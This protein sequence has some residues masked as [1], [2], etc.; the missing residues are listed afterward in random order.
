MKANYSSEPDLFKLPMEATLSFRLMKKKETWIEAGVLSSPYTNESPFSKD[1]FVYSRSFAADNVP[2]YL[3]GLKFTHPLSKRLKMS[4]YIL[5]GWQQIKDQN[6]QKSFATQL[7]FR[8][9]AKNLLN[10]NTYF[11]DERSTDHPTYRMRYFSDVYWIYNA[12]GKFSLTAC[13]YIGLQEQIV[14]NEKKINLWWQ[15]NSSLRYRFSNK[16]ALS[17]RL[18]YFSDP[19]KTIIS[20]ITSA[21]GFN[22]F[23]TALNFSFPIKENAVLRLE[24][25]EWFSIHEALFRDNEQKVINNLRILTASMTFWL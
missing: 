24:A 8:P 7:E 12:D 17:A 4:L 20:T 11:G 23:G 21:N 6:N 9:N 15:L 22:Y 16:I 14:Q 5:N 13:S 10:W 19:N 25:K 18:E 3:C 1:Q 2:Y